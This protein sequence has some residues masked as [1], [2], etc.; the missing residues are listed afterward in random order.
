MPGANFYPELEIND[1]GCLTP[2][3][4][5]KLAKGEI[6]LRLDVWIWQDSRACMAVLRDFPQRDRWEIIT[7]AH[8]NH[9]GSGF[10]PGAAAAMG[11]MVTEMENGETKTFQWT[12]AIFLHA[13]GMP[14]QNLMAAT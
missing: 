12:D 11:I 4:P 9:V 5:M 6:V 13:K 14:L 10:R 1:H 8:E 3:G 7:D 2:A